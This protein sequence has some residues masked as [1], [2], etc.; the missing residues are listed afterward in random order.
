V[1]GLDVLSA[2]SASAPPRPGRRRA[3]LVP[4][5]S[6]LLLG[7]LVGGGA[8]LY[9]R[10]LQSDRTIPGLRLGATP[11]PAL[12]RL[13]LDRILAEEAERFV[14]QPVVLQVG[15]SSLTVKRHQIGARASLSE[16]RARLLATG[17]TGDFLRDLI[18]RVQARRGRLVVPIETELDRDTALE[19]FTRLKE[20][21]D[22]PPIAARLDLDRSL[23]VPAVEGREL[24]VYDCLA[25]AE[26][27]LGRHRTTI[28]LA[29]TTRSAGSGE[30]LKTLEIGQVLGTFTTVYS[31][32]DKDADRAHN[33]KVA[34]G[35]LD[36]TI[37]E[38]G[39][40]FSFN[41]TVG[42]RTEKEGYRTAPVISEGELVDGMAGGACQLSS[43][44]FAAAFFA[45]LELES[46]RPHTRPS[47]YIKMGLDAA[48]AY[49]GTDLVLKNSYPFPVVIHYKVNQGKV[50]VRLLGK[51]RPWRK[52][53]FERVIKETIPFKT[54]VKSS[55][56]IPKGHRVV[57]Q[58]GV[59]GFR[60]ERRRL[61][62]GKG[63]E[64]EKIEKREVNYPPTT[65]LIR[66]G[67]GPKDPAWTPPPKPHP[68]GDAPPE[69][70]LSQ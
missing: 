33:L 66:E 64:P 49:P 67:T 41:Q 20:E 28:R 31:L 35:K 65:E 62:Y 43:T 60:C 51:Q 15:S 27:A 12:D 70:T 58:V 37:L 63:P 21:I 44:L 30:R 50:T 25:A 11:L 46:S 32:A 40:T 56:T 2:A 18:D 9:R 6:L 39:A 19:F 52:V 68:F 10:S 42:R 38:P 48:V 14:E 1:Q 57:T 34:A 23:V 4:A 69:F 8:L 24:R 5:G 7:L 61:L 3:W 47:S 53:V 16:T 55:A 29:M 22:R 26:L 36:G 54:E 45:G 17:K 13:E 59:P